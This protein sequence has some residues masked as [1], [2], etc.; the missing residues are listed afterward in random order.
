MD[1][2]APKNAVSRVSQISW[3]SGPFP[4]HKGCRQGY[5]L[6]TY[7][8]IPCAEILSQA[9]IN[10]KETVGLNIKG[11]EKKLTQFADD[12]SLFLNGTK[13]TLRKAIAVLNIYEEAS[14]LKIN[15]SKT[16]A[17]WIGSKH[18]SNEVICHEVEL[19]WVKSFTAPGI[20]Y[21]VTNLQGI[22]EFNCKTKMTEVEKVE[23][24]N[25][26]R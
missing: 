25:V 17:I 15:L 14:G 8:L 5:P 4:L 20:N 26:S 18:L 3:L 16:K 13:R 12:T 19:D 22:T 2:H 7:I 6:S 11:E 1:L 21:V 24:Y 9:I 10:S 23:K